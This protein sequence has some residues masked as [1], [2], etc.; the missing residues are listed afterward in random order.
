MSTVL[1]FIRRNVSL[2]LVALVVL[3]GRSSLA[4]H[5]V[6]PSGSMEHTLVP[7]DRVFVDKLAYGLRV[8]FTS[9]VLHEGDA[10]QAGDIAIFD[11]PEDGT[12]LIKRIVAVGGDRVQLKAGHLWING[13]RIDD[14]ERPGWELFPGGSAHLN[15]AYGGG[16]DFPETQVPADHVLM[17]GDSRGN[18]RDGRFFGF[19]PASSLYARAV[20][21]YY[22]SGEGLGWQ[23]F[24]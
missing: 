22:R 8:P 14:P 16:E 17:M 5:Y 2:L 6:V 20:A 9:L 18:S 4:D 19:L 7:G 13:R 23:K 10:P 11:S 24:Q 21:I 1:G 15:L 12:R 3:A